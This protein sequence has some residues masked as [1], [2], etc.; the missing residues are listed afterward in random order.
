MTEVYLW[1]KFILVIITFAKKSARFLSKFLVKNA[2]GENG[3]MTST[4]LWIP[5]A[6]TDRGKSVATA[7]F[8]TE[9]DHQA[10]SKIF[11]VSQWSRS[12]N[13]RKQ[14]I[15]LGKCLPFGKKFVL[16]EHKLHKKAQWPIGYGVGLRIKRSSVRI[17]PWPLRWV[18]GQ[19]SLLPLSQGE[20]FTLASIS[21]LAILVKY[22]L[23]KKKKKKKKKKNKKKY[24]ERSATGGFAD[25][26]RYSFLWSLSHASLDPLE[27]STLF[28]RRPPSLL[29]VS[30]YGTLLLGR[31]SHPFFTCFFM[32]AM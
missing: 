26:S 6:K 10:T 4:K 29:P 2:C 12:W 14:K 28:G 11:E 16:M 17:R 21:Y 22:I 19:G 25:L 24:R 7:S 23:A 27:L 1:K 13:Q 20:A 32:D 8:T 15:C 3:F 5:K 31:W 9:V 30:S 18:L